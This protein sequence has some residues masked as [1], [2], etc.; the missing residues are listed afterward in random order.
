M[1]KKYKA[2]NM[3]EM[4]T[5]ISGRQLWSKITDNLVFSLVSYDHHEVT[6]LE[7]NVVIIVLK[8][9]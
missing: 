9:R 7:E 8:I 6:L 2:S 1:T 3:R 5:P 4:K